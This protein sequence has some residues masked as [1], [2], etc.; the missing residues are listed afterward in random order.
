MLRTERTKI[1]MM[2]LV[3]FFTKNMKNI[4]KTQ[5]PNQSYKPD[6]IKS[7]AYRDTTWRIKVNLNLDIQS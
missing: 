3:D 2:F 4:I 5:K 7:R 1:K 6:Y